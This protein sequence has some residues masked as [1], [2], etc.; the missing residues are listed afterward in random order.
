MP[1][2]FIFPFFIVQERHVHI[3]LLTRKHKFKHTFFAVI[4]VKD[5]LQVV[6]ILPNPLSVHHFKVP[7]NLRKVYHAL[8]YLHVL[9]AFAKVG[10]KAFQLIL[11]PLANLGRGMFARKVFVYVVGNVLNVGKVG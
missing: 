7:V 2:A 9:L 4:V 6:G 5:K 11:P 10:P 1:I 3:G 8:H